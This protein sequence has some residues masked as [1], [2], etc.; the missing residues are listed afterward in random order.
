MLTLR[1]IAR[2]GTL[3][4]IAAC[5][6]GEATQ[7]GVTRADSAGVRIVTSAAADTALSWSFEE[8]DVLADTVGEGEPYL[9]TRLWGRN[10]LA[11]RAGRVYVLTRDPAIL[12]FGRDGR[13]ERSIGRQGGGPGEMQLPGVLASSGD[14]LVVLDLVKRALVRWAPTLDPLADRRLEGTLERADQ[15]AFRAGGLWFQ[16]YA[17]SDSGLVSEFYADTIGPPLH[18]VVTPSGGPVKFK[19]IALSQSTPLFSPTVTWSASG[20]RV[21][22]NQGPDYTLWLYEGRRPVASVRRTVRPRAPTVDDVRAEHPEGYKVS[23]GGD[24][25]PCITPVEEVMKGFGVAAV[26]PAVHDLVL[27][28]DGTIWVQRTPRAATEQVIDVFAPD[29]AYVGTTRGMKL[30]VGLLP[31]G[32]MLVPRFDEANGGLVLGRVRVGR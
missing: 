7:P 25:P 19:C 1:V 21:L 22:A 31:N 3:L 16:R 12:R 14:T 8:V 18:S 5:V 30:P 11:D 9:F 32:Q 26:F 2:A 4:A 24:R 27:L 29:G 13:L 20:P 17:F 15:I 10:V 23:F 28:P 6:R